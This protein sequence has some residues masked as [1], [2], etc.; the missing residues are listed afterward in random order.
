MS[1]N[2]SASEP[3]CDI[4]PIPTK[5]SLDLLAIVLTPPTSPL[6]FFLVW[7]HMKFEPYAKGLSTFQVKIKVHFFRSQL[8]KHCL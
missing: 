8:T 3:Q 4:S 2:C 6:P 7:Q 5:V 1:D